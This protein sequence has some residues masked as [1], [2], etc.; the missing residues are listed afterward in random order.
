MT[1]LSDIIGHNN[2]VTDNDEKQ[3]MIVVYKS[4]DE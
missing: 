2:V 4:G 3:I 1:T